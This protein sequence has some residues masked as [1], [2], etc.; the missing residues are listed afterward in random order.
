MRA[1]VRTDRPNEPLL[2]VPALTPE[3]NAI[4]LPQNLLNRAAH[5]SKLDDSAP[6][7]PATAPVSTPEAS[8]TP[9]ETAH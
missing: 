1:N 8:S 6:V 4:L 5:P 9:A 3:S 2:N 7:Q